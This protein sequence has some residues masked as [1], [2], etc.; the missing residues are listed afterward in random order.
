MIKVNNV[1]QSTDSE[2][3]QPVFLVNIS[4]PIEPMM[5]AKDMDK[6]FAELGKSLFTGVV[7]YLN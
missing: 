5:E 6:F 1:H 3:F 2:T 4:I 7:D